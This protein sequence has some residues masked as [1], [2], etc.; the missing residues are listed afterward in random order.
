MYKHA[1]GHVHLT[2]QWHS[3]YPDAYTT[4]NISFIGSTISATGLLTCGQ[5]T[6]LMHLNEHGF[7]E[8]RMFY[9]SDCNSAF[10]YFFSEMNMDLENEEQK[11]DMIITVHLF[12]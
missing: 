7:R 8:W 12:L 4:W 1:V 2:Q 6:F 11:F 9:L 10:N 3:D 5:N